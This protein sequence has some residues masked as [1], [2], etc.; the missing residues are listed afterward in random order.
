MIIKNTKGRS[1]K[2]Q[3]NTE[4]SQFQLRKFALLFKLIGALIILFGGYWIYMNSL[5]GKKSD[6]DMSSELMCGAENL[7]D[8]Y[9]ISNGV[10]FSNGKTRSSKFSYAGEYSSKLDSVN[11]YG[12]SIKLENVLPQQRYIV[13]V[14]RFIEETGKF[15][16][17]ISPSPESDL[18]TQTNIMKSKDED[19]WELIELQ[20]TVPNESEIKYLTIYPYRSS[21]T[22][23]AYFDDLKIEIIPVE[24]N[25]GKNIDEVHLYLDNKALNKINIKRNEALQAGILISADDD[26]V[27]AKLTENDSLAYDVKLRLKGDWTDHLQGDYWSY[28]IKMPSDKS[29]NRMQTF[30][31][32]DP[33]ARSYLDEWLYHKAL[34]SIDVITPR[35][36][37]VKLSQNNQDPVLY[38][39]EEHFEKQIAEYKNRREGV[40]LKFSEDQL[41]DDRM[42]NA[43]TGDDIFGDIYHNSEI[44][45]FK[46]S[47]TLK[48]PKLKEQF[49]R[50]QDLLNSYKNRSSDPSEIF[51]MELLGKYFA[52]TE[53][54]CAYHGIIWHN[55][56][57]YYNPISRKLE[58][59]GYDGFTDKGKLRMYGNLFFGEFR[60]EDTEL[61]S[62]QKYNYIYQNPEFNEYYIAGLVEYSSEEFITKLIDDNKDEIEELE[63][64]VKVN[65]DAKYKLDI[66]DIKRRASKIYYNIKPSNEH[67]LKAYRSNSN[68]D[69][70]EI[71]VSNY[72]CLPLEVVGTGS[73]KTWSEREPLSQLINS[74][75]RLKPAKYTKVFSKV[76]DKYVYYRLPKSKE[77][78]SSR[79]KKWS[80]AANDLKI[81]YSENTKLS[82]P[83]A[84]SEYEITEREIRILPG[85]HLLNKPLIIPRSYNLTVEPGAMIDM[86]NKAYILSYGTLSSVGTSSS[87]ILF[88]SS[89]KSSQG[90]AVIKSKETCEIKHTSFTNLNTLEENEWQLTGAV[91]FYES[92]VDMANVTI[93]RNLCEDALNIVRATFSI[94]EL[95]INNTFG[96]GFDCDFCKGK[97]T[98]SYLF[99]TGNDALDYSG[100]YIEL[101]NMRLENI[102]DK[103]ISAGEEA[104]VIVNNTTI[105]GA[106]IGIASKDLSIVEVTNVLLKDC[107]QGFAAYRKKPEF[108]GAII[109]INSF[110]EDNVDRLINK[111]EESKINLP[112]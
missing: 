50:A 1:S 32:Q 82:I 28:R 43:K 76:D 93:S 21:D 36:G 108:G 60:S 41:W 79:I 42:N 9:F 45:P 74:N 59:I 14:R 89:D 40:I 57:F 27:K 106:Q 90:V 26:W 81:R 13:S 4:P 49:L 5:V 64:L 29:W 22:G 112:K 12:F 62:D 77:I 73:E 71:E 10:A 91:T 78:F 80:P 30:S 55:A 31:L 46:E 107:L 25:F 6:S 58:P 68:L 98:N 111:D 7:V 63:F 103:G 92:D 2:H 19:G 17:V 39:Y 96:D 94:N 72:H 52:M 102:G 56:R 83:L 3:E 18:Y 51:D 34:E 20:F 47:K 23:I 109:N 75:G 16:L 86:R 35:Y 15:P 88:T 101:E 33:K 24:E 11:K 8:G 95:N 48:S 70:Q 97:L 84:D 53:V 38:A 99:D 110:N 66:K 69:S 67:S 85:K 105:T 104:T 87:P 61:I 44:A 65:I 100:S 37:F 54:L